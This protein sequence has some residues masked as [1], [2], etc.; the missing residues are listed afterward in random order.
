MWF[1]FLSYGL[2]GRDSIPV[3]GKKFSLLLS[4]QTGS[5]AHPASYPIGTGGSFPGGKAARGVKLTTPPSSAEV[6]N[7]GV[8]PPLPYTFSWRGAYL[9]KH[10][11]SFFSFLW[12]TD[13]FAD[14][15]RRLAN[16]I[17]TSSTVRCLSS[18]HFDGRDAPLLSSR[19]T[20]KL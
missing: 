19:T 20:L 1:P 11:D 10:R 18:S 8:V 12:W 13:I 16:N 9:I 3:R 5:R 4:V 15:N 2:D 7:G 17:L 6:K 14:V